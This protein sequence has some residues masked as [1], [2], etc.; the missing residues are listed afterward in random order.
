MEYGKLARRLEKNTGAYVSPSQVKRYLDSHTELKNKNYQDT[1]RA[2]HRYFLKFA[3]EL[4][5]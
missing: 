3:D 4:E 5:Q 1:Y 2:L